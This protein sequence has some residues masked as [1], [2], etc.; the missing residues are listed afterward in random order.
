MG[1][2]NKCNKRIAAPMPRR[3]RTDKTCY[4]ILYL[5][6]EALSYSRM[7]IGYGSQG[8]EGDQRLFYQRPPGPFAKIEPL[9]QG[10]ML[11]SL[12]GRPFSANETSFHVA[13][14]P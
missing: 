7:R 1:T 3:N 11:N 6:S 12:S 9:F 8:K 2:L 14:F 13:I 10:L 5:Y 4:H